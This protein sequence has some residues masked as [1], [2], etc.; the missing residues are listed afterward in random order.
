MAGPQP[1]LTPNPMHSIY[2]N[3]SSGS[4]SPTSSPSRRGGFHH[5]EAGVGVLGGCLHV[6]VGGGIVTSQGG[7]QG[8]T[9]QHGLPPSGLG[10]RGPQGSMPRDGGVRGRGGAGAG[11]HAQQGYG[12]GS[13]PGGYAPRSAHPSHPDPSEPWDR[14]A[15]SAPPGYF[16][17]PSLSL[18]FISLSLSL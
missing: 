7:S 4:S 17:S 16:L 18:S 9:T 2:I 8:T 1:G 14:A 15:V 10:C 13:G 5:P 12:R 6:G 3:H 11:S